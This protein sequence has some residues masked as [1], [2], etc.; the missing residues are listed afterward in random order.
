MNDVTKLSQHEIDRL[1]IDLARRIREVDS[2][3][4]LF[5]EIDKE[6]GNET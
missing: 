2:V 6:L 5:K 4:E 3:D 1:S